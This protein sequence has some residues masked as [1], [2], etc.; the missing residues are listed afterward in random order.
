MTHG[1]FIT[2][3][4]TGVGKTYVTALIAREAKA[5]GVRVGI[6]KPVCSGGVCGADGAVVWPDLTA[7]S[8][9]LDHRCELD[10]ISPQRF[11]APLAPPVAA[12][13]EGKSVD[14]D[15]LRSGARWWQGRVDLLLIEGAGGLLCPLTERETVADLAADLGCPLLIVARL[16]LGT[17]NHTLL[18]VEAAR[19]RGLPIAG[20]LLNDSDPGRTGPEAESNPRELAARCP[21]PVLGVLPHGSTGELLRDGRTIRM[22]WFALAAPAARLQP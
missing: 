4:D 9:A 14:P 15:L 2:G 7:L 17:I 11:A 18:T 22:D 10:R 3:T 20:V 16:A 8:A 12:R 19:H 13:R 1:L 21:V 5:R 6:Y